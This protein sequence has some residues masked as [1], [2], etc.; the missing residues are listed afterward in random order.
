MIGSMSLGL[1]IGVGLALGQPTRRVV[2]LDGD[3][4]VLMG[5]SSLATAATETVPNLVHIVLDNGVHDSTGGQRTIS[6]RIELERV[7][8]A[9]GYRASHRVE[10]E[11]AFQSALRQVLQGPP[12]GPIMVLGRVEP[13]K[14][15]GIGRVEPPPPE[16]AE[17]FAKRAQA[18]PRGAR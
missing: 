15:P 4:N 13:G 8:L 12:Q 5:L 18:S 6:D 11:D 17:R 7:A 9:A 1:S 14:V 3:G 16:L 10:T 2:V